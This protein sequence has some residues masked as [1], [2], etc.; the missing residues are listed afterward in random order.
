MPALTAD[1]SATSDVDGP[2]VKYEHFGVGVYPYERIPSVGFAMSGGG[3][4]AAACAKGTFCSLLA[5]DLFAAKI[6]HVSVCSGSSWTAYPTFYDCKNDSNNYSVAELL[7]GALDITSLSSADV[8]TK[9]QLP[10]VLVNSA[11]ANILVS[12]FDDVLPPD[13][14]LT[15]AF[16][17]IF[18]DQFH[19]YHADKTCTMAKDEEAALF[20]LQEAG[21][22]YVYH[23][24]SDMP[25]LVSSATV[26]FP[27]KEG[28]ERY[29]IDT[30]AAS[31]GSW[32]LSDTSLDTTETDGGTGELVVGG[33]RV[34]S[35]AHDAKKRAG[36]KEVVLKEHPYSLHDALATTSLPLEPLLHSGISSV[37]RNFVPQYNM[38]TD[39]D[40]NKFRCMDGRWVCE[41]HCS[42][43]PFG[44]QAPANC[45]LHQRR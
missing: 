6:S 30:T 3:A 4:T 22:D 43:K 40:L 29:A 44:A 10:D 9:P 8:T 28:F 23:A 7:G 31:V 38:T 18:L 32:G 12:L 17:Q 41:W 19:L 35:F 26:C 13:R 11:C 45:V 14:L 42:S 36:E 1:T 37:L 21:M 2:T 20:L 34:S 25:T 27:P 5:H 16:G 15:K 33:G 24:R 39:Q